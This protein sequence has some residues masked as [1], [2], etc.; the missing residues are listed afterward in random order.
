MPWFKV[1]DG[2]HAHHKVAKLGPDHSDALALWVVAGSWSAD[3]LTDGWVPEYVAARLDIHYAERAKALVRV[4]LWV[5]AERDGEPGWLFHGWSEPGRNPTSEQVKA[6]REAT[7]ERQRRF[8]D[9]IKGTKKDAG[10]PPEVA[11]ETPAEDPES[12]AVTNGLVTEPVPFRSVPFLSIEEEPLS[13]ATA[14][15][16]PDNT[17]TASKRTRQAKPAAKPRADVE[18]LCNRLVELMVENGSDKPKITDAWRT[19][20]RLLLDKD[21]QEHGHREFDKAM[22]LLEWAL[23]DTFWWKNIRSIPKFRIQYG[24]LR[25]EANDQWVRSRP[26]VADGIRTGAEVAPYAG[27]NVVAIRPNIPAPRPSTTD[28]AVASGDAAL[29]EFRRMTGRTA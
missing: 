17:N 23:K 7:A 4:G 6:E 26:V 12:N 10:N 5:A 19:Q 2:F 9:K 22:R 16:R 29:A 13:S 18:A 15:P 27:G 25:D 24:K 8:R 1:D 20:A 11:P 3:Q 14:T 21:Q 28:R